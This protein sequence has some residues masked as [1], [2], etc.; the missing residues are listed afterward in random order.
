MDETSQLEYARQYF[1]FV[2]NLT[3]EDPYNGGV[4]FDWDMDQGYVDEFE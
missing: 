3:D 2:N 4:P 1:E